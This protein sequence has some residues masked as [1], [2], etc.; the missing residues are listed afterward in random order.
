MGWDGIREREGSGEVKAGGGDM[1][2]VEEQIGHLIGAW[3]Q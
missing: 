2:V 1:L 3:E